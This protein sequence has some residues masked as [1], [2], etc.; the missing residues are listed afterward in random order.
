M[1]RMKALWMKKSPASTLTEK[2]WLNASCT[3]ERGTLFQLEMD[4]FSATSQMQNVQKGEVR[5]QK[6]GSWN[7]AEMH[8]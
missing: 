6:L 4:Q 8:K 3:K 7:E 5:M 1:K 2:Q